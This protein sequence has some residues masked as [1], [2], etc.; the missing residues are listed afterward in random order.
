MDFSKLTQQDMQL[1]SLLTQAPTSHD[2]YIILLYKDYGF[3]LSKTDFAK[4]IKKSEQTVD[5]RIK[6]ARNIPKYLKS[7]DGAKASYIFPVLEVANYL[8]STI[9]VA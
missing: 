4:L 2:K 7:S 1:A 9:K 5:R 8:C 3:T 6:E